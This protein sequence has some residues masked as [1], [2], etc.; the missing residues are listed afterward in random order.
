MR[1]DCKELTLQCV[2]C[3]RNKPSRHRPY[4]LLQPL[5]VPGRPW[6]SISMDFVE[7][8]PTSNGLSWWLLTVWPSNVVSFQPRTLVLPRTLQMHS[9]PMCSQSTASLSMC[10]LTADR[11]SPLLGSLLR[12]RLH[13]TSG[14][15]PSDN[16]QVERVNTTLEQY[17]RFYYN[18]EQ[19]NWS[20]SLPLA[21][22]APP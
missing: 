18:Y 2:L 11:D 8:L 5:P 13:F 1:T 21:E 4:S 22:F 10:P 7:H 16:G 20:T 9:L 3:A 6:Y 17:L 14:H 12:M 15:H 19:G